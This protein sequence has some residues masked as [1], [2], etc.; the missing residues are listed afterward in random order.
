MSGFELAIPGALSEAVIVGPYRYLLRRVWGPEGDLLTFV[1]LNP[2]TADAQT[3]DPTI[4]R[5]IGFAKREGCGGINVL[6]LY[7][8]RCTDPAQLP[9]APDPV[10]PEND[11]Y[12]RRLAEFRG[13]VERPPANI[14]V[15][16]GTL[17]G[18]MRI[19]QFITIMDGTPLRCLGVT[20]GG[21]P[22]HPLYVRSDQP[23][24]PW[25]WRTV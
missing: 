17:A 24:V 3:D 20:K 11:E 9:R 8:Y 5:C 13:I 15:A 16:W 21:Q 23:L 12:L 6:N 10:G 25:D 19:A 14:V 1:M 2:S 22:R 4:R 7:A 18:Q